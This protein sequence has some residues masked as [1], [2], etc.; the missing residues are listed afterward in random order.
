MLNHPIEPGRSDARP[1]TTAH[2][3][4]RRLT[5]GQLRVL[6][7]TRIAY[8]T[9]PRPGDGLADYVVRGADG[10]AVAAFDELDLVL[11]VVDRLGLA[12][13]PVH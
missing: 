9:G 3:D 4:A 1:Q 5:A 13:V 10:V 7:L 12:L 11:E 2:V 6:G 8:L